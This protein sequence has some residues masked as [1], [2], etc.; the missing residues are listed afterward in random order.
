MKKDIPIFSPGDLVE[1]VYAPDQSLYHRK[2]FTGKLGVII[3]RCDQY[4]HDGVYSS[5][6]IYNVFIDGVYINLHALDFMLISK[7]KE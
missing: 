5:P 3:K 1:F 2:R 6:N 7:V 4:E